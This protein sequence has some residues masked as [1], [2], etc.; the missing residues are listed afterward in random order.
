MLQQVFTWHIEHRGSPFPLA[1]LRSC[2]YSQV[3]MQ[4]R[5]ILFDLF[6]TGS[7]ARVAVSRVP[8]LEASPVSLYPH[9]LFSAIMIENIYEV[10]FLPD[11]LSLEVE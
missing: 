1:Q 4:N 6:P 11:P 5:L 3:I 7:F 9:P 2:A 8:I 10:L